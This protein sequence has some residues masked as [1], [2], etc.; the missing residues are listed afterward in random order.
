M[1]SV[2][3]FQAACYPP[4]PPNSARPESIVQESCNALDDDQDGRID[5]QSRCFILVY[6]VVWTDDTGDGDLIYGADDRLP[7]G[8][9]GEPPPDVRCSPPGDCQDPQPAFS[10]RSRAVPGSKLL[11]MAYDPNQHEHLLTIDEEVWEEAL[12]TGFKDLGELGYVFPLGSPAG[13]EPPQ[14]E[15]LVAHSPTQTARVYTTDAAE[16]T[17]PGGTFEFYQQEAPCCLVYSPEAGSW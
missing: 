10:V 2:L 11:R 5:E 14:V 6:R 8:F 3:V 17:E 7:A 1:G 13:G 15:L 4:P 16:L 9:G 12:D